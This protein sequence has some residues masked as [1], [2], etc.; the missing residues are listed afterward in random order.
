MEYKKKAGSRRGE[1]GEE[2]ARE[3]KEEEREEEVE[4]EGG[5]S[6]Q[7][8]NVRSWLVGRKYLHDEVAQAG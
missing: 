8:G 7:F 6:H 5:G 3:G 1:E 4:E 2:E